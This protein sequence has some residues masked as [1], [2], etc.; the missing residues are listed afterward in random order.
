M[1][2][3]WFSIGGHY[4]TQE[5]VTYVYMADTILKE[6]RN[7]SIRLDGHVG[8]FVKI[9]LYFS[10]VW[11]SISEVAFDSE[12]ATGIFQAEEKP[13]QLNNVGIKEHETETST[14]AAKTHGNL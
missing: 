9:E 4:Y 8:Q 6:P 10:N 1:A 12:P 2:V 3:V 11:L 7:V 14:E 13:P 5:P